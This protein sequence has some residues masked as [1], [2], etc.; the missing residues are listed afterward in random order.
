MTSA[1]LPP[2]VLVADDQAD[3]VTALR[4]LLKDAGIATE[5]ATSMRDVISRLDSR[6]Y[7]LLL[8]DLNYERDTTSGR[9]GLELLSRVRAKDDLLPVVVM[10]GWSSVETAVEAMRLGARNYVCKPWNNESLVTMVRHEIE[11]GAALR[12]DHDRAARELAQARSTQ[13]ALLPET[14]PA[15]AAGDL[16]AR[17]EPA[18]T[19][20]GDCYDALV[21]DESHTALSIGDVCGKG[22]PAAFLMSHLQAS[23]RALASLEAAPDAVVAGVNRALCRH[24]DLQRFVTLFYAVYDQ[25]SRVLLFSNAGHNPPL[26]M[27]RDGAVERLAAGGTVTGVFEEAAYET[28]R[29]TLEPGDRLLLFTDGVTEARSP[30]GAEFGD[31]RLAAILCE[32]PDLDAEGTLRRVFAD[33][34]AFSQSPLQDDATAVALWLPAD[35]A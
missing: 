10:T 2:T 31:E 14:L 11:A 33:I 4:L 19:F 27:R 21:L 25:A 7:D 29:V 35:A 20:G 3:V 28:G 30:G 5:P 9:E 6:S 16:A 24:G 34:A 32:T 8:M 22:L 23:V 13:R 1:G 15:V 12:H 26:L 17:W 18:S